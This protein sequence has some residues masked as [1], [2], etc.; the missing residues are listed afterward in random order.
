LG[1]ELGA[2]WVIANCLMTFGALAGRV[3]QLG[4]AARLFGAGEAFAEARGVPLGFRH[5]N[6]YERTVRRVRAALGEDALAAAYAEGR[7]L[8]LD[9]A[10]ALALEQTGS[11]ETPPAGVRPLPDGLTPRE[12]EVLGLIAAGLSNREIAET[13]VVSERTVE[14]HADNIYGKIGARGRSKARQYARAHGLTSPAP[15]VDT[16]SG[17]SG[18]LTGRQ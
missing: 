2:A 9:A 8:T 4:R 13:L 18:S 14:R 17:P 1:R 12:A 7:A 16:P 11:G 6:P 3:G 5:Y 10:V 15:A